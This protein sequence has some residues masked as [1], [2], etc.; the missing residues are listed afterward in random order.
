MRMMIN[1]FKK[2]LRQG[3]FVWVFAGLF[4]PN[5]LSTFYWGD[6]STIGYTAARNCLKWSRVVCGGRVTGF[7]VVR[8]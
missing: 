1:L 4:K 5:R 8:A 7:P 6:F 3:L 2:G